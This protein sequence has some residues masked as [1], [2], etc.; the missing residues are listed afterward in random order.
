M[1]SSP[2]LPDRFIAEFLE[3]A[4]SAHVYF[5]L[6]NDRLTMRA[7]NPHWEMWHPIRH[8]LDEI[9][10]EALEMHLRRSQ[11]ASGV[12]HETAAAVIAACSNWWGAAY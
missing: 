10:A 2:P 1:R 11:N 3:I 12:P 8:M 7:V 6:V 9:G 4:E 5:D